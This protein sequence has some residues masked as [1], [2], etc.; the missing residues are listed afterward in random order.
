MLLSKDCIH[1]YHVY[2]LVSVM[3]FAL[4]FVQNKWSLFSEPDYPYLD[5]L[6][7][8]QPL[9]MRVNKS[10]ISY[11]TNSVVS[12]FIF[13]MHFKV[14]IS[15]LIL[16]HTCIHTCKFFAI[17]MYMYYLIKFNNCSNV[18]N[19]QCVTLSSNCSS[20]IAMIWECFALFAEN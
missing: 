1:F 11:N 10:Y 9:K 8:F 14:Y 18:L 7:P 15:C 13:R 3:I 19:F 16:M 12:K 4:L 20:L 6:S 5:A 17:F 2:Y